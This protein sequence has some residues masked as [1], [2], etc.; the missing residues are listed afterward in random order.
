MKLN[1]FFKWTLRILAGLVA[2]IVLALLGVFLWARAQ[3]S[4]SLPELAGER[5]V[6]GLGAGVTIERDGLGIPTIRAAN[7]NDVAFATGFLHAQ[8]RFFQMDI[9]RRQSAG[10]M[11]ELLGRRLL[12]FDR[13][14]RIHRFRH[15]AQELVRGARDDERALVEAYAA[16][17][18]A[19][20]EAA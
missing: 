3:V 2:L 6:D 18:N 19:G 9:L 4:G 12:G 10:E 1:R 7:R 13:G 11:A 8:E 5:T 17:V 14:M 16:G 20:L 15:F